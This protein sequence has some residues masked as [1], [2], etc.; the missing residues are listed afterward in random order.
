MSL[1]TA[2]RFGW[3]RYAALF[4][5]VTALVASTAVVLGLLA[6]SIIQHNPFNTTMTEHPN[7]VVLA[8]VHDLARFEA[9]TGRF[10][11]I[12]DQQHTS[13]ALP[14]W[15]MGER[16]VLAAEGD[17]AASVDLANLP[18]GAIQLS[19]DGTHAT[20]HVPAPTLGTPKL[21][22]GATRVISRDRGVLNRVG[23]AVGNGDP[24]HQDQLERRASD[25]LLAAAEQSDL[26]ARAKAN[27]EAFLRD[28]LRSAGVQD[29]TV[30]FDA[31]IT[32][33][34]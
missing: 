27:T 34:A 32:S 6:Y 20:V 16:V 18:D 4:T 31:P 3:R 7:S 26:R 29:V 14:E 11:T 1:A 24:V 8:Q 22:P 15:A 33:P 25:K 19:T 30:V 23:E 2:A 9:A 21:D 10:Q 28:T 13:E 5:V 12:V 17:V